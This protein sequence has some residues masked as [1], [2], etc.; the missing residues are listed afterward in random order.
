MSVGRGI[1]PDRH[2]KGKHI[3]LT[4]RGRFLPLHETTCQWPE[5]CS[6]VPPLLLGERRKTGLP[7][8]EGEERGDGRSEGGEGEG[9]EGGRS[10]LV[11]EK[12]QSEGSTAMY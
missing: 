8:T 12:K 9:G 11:E 7:L 1:K 10:I 3:S 5:V 2:P 6:P 4:R